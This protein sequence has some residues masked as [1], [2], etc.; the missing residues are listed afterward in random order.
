MKTRIDA[1]I[2]EYFT[3]VVNDDKKEDA[4]V[5][6]MLDQVREAF[7]LDV[8][9]VVENTNYHFDFEYTF[10]SQ[11]KVVEPDRVRLFHLADPDYAKIIAKYAEEELGE[12][13]YESTK[14][15]QYDYVLRYVLLRK[16]EIQGSA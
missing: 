5:M 4:A 6:R 1:V 11:K 9:Y 15:L 8:V 3:S 16:N 14:A 2:G 7:D 10:L 13:Q 12:E